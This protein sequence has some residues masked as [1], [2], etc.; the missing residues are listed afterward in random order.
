MVQRVVTRYANTAEETESGTARDYRKKAQH[1]ARGPRNPF[2][3]SDL[4]NV[5]L[6][7]IA[8]V[9]FAGVLDEFLAGLHAREN[10]R[11]LPGLGIGLGIVE[12]QFPYAMC[13]RSVSW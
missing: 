7:Q 6:G 10:P 8:I 2:N 1:F 9:F 3:G 4:F 5:A 11:V 13:S 12:G